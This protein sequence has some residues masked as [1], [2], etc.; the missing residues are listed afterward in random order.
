MQ[1]LEKE[2][3]EIVDKAFEVVQ[4]VPVNKFL[5]RL[6]NLSL[7]QKE[8]DGKFI[9]RVNAELHKDSTL[10]N[11]WIKLN[12]Y[13]NFLNYFL[14]EQ[15][16]HKFGDNT[17]KEDMEE[18]KKRLKHF[19][20]STK[21]RDFAKYSTKINKDLSEENMSLLVMKLEKHW[22]ECTLEDLENFTEKFTHKLFVS[23]FSLVLKEVKPGCIQ[24]TWSLHSALVASLKEKT[25]DLREFCEEHEI[26]RISIDDITIELCAGQSYK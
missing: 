23:E 22:D 10:I 5:A 4:E 8:V 19:R 11:I 24:V 26:M 14:L 3:Q 25:E 6:S 16:V 17:L 21:L 1:C 13:W 12:R 2:F 15:V 9:D 20:C 7:E 18:Y